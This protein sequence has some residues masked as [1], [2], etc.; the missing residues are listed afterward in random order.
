MSTIYQI[1]SPDGW[2]GKDGKPRGLTIVEC[3]VCDWSWGGGVFSAG[4]AFAGHMKKHKK[5]KEEG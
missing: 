1:D 4:S 2:L 5:K 3:S